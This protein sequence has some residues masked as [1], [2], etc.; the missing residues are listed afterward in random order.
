MHPFAKDVSGQ[1]GAKPLKD[2][3][4]MKKNQDKYLGF[5]PVIAPLIMGEGVGD[6]KTT[7]CVMAQAATI[8][9]LRKGKTLDAPTDEME[10][11][12]PVLRRIAIRLN[13]TRWWKNNVERTEHLRPLIPLL[14][15]SKGDETLTDKRVFFAADHAVRDLTPVRLEF[16]AKN[17]KN[18]NVKQDCLD[19]AK[20]LRGL[21]RIK[22]KASA[23]KASEVCRKLRAYASA[24]AYAYASANANAYAYADEQKL[25]YRAMCVQLFKDLAA[26]K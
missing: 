14:L 25:R 12:C 16:I 4:T 11:A 13:D 26:L 22:D 15:D 24:D 23:L 2:N 20:K 10:C 8:D 21:S 6:G 7:A 1:W 3:L 9:A 5:Y 19:G 17:T 18:E